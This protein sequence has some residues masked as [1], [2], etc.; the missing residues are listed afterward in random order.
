MKNPYKSYKMKLITLSPIFIGSGEELN[1]GQYIFD[2]AQSNYWTLSRSCF[3]L[4]GDDIYILDFYYDFNA[5]GT[6]PNNSF[7]VRPAVTLATGTQIMSGD[8]T[9]GNPYKIL[10]N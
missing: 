5:N 6:M 7:G 2:N 9:I 10:E 1:Q 8:G 4:V 3:D